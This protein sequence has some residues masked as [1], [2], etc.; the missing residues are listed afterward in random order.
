V[1]SIKPTSIK[2]GRGFVGKTTWK[3]INYLPFV[4]PRAVC[5]GR[6]AMRVGGRRVDDNH[7]KLRSVSESVSHTE[8]M[9]NGPH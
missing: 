7:L 4:L 6:D 1:P 2:K 5:M 3:N 8:A 9:S